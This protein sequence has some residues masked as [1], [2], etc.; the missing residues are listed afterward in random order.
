MFEDYAKMGPEKVTAIEMVKGVASFP[1]VALGGTGE[2]FISGLS[3][4][5]TVFI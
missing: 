4:L 2:Y 1:V 5:Y 3:V